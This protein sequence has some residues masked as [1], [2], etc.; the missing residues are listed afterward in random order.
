MIFID[1]T[2]QQ[3]LHKIG[4]FLMA[5]LMMASVVLMSA[6]RVHAEESSDF[7]P[8][9][10][11]PRNN[12]YYTSKNKYYQ[13]GYGMPNCTAYAYGRAYEIL[14]S[15]PKLAMGNAYEWYGYNKNNNCY[16]YGRSPRLG[17]IACWGRGH[18]AVVEK[19]SGDKITI[20]ES[21]YSGK[22]F[23]TKTLTRGKESNYVGKFQGYIYIL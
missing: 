11:A 21:H 22:Y 12:A 14:K 3:V 10:T 6:S 1:T 20:S 17:A 8:R 5:L 9:T 19:I 23:D 4:A 2:K 15:K 16:D 7:T 13:T 18:V